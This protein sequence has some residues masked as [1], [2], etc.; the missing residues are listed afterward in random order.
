MPNQTYFHSSKITIYT[1]IIVGQIVYSG[2]KNTLSSPEKATETLFSTLKALMAP[3]FRYYVLFL[4]RDDKQRV[5]YITRHIYPAYF[6][7]NKILH[8]FASLADLTKSSGDAKLAVEEKT[9]VII[10][11]N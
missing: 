7:N 5:W 6:E 2:V 11:K 1:K 8:P 4:F 9:D 3:N 10:I